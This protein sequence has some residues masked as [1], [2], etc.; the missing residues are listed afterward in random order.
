MQ[1][2]DGVTFILPMRHLHLCSTQG[3]P[4]NF[5]RASL[6]EER[7][8]GWAGEK[9]EGVLADSPK[10]QWKKIAPNDALPCSPVSRMRGAFQNIIRANSKG[11]GKVKSS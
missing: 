11:K 10:R 8:E 7:E 1:N 2:F 9:R 4:I 5:E 6:L 3:R